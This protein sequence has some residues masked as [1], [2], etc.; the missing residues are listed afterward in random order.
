MYKLKRFGTIYN[1]NMTKEIEDTINSDEFQMRK[2][3]EKIEEL[4][5]TIKE[6]DIEIN[7]LKEQNNN[8]NSFNNSLPKITHAWKMLDSEED[9]IS[10]NNNN[11]NIEESDKYK[12]VL[13]ELN[14]FKN[15]YI[16]IKEDYIK[17]QK[18]NKPKPVDVENDE[19]YL[20]LKDKYDNLLYDKE[21]NEYEEKINI[22]QNTIKELN[23][24]NKHK[25]DV[26]NNENV[27][28]PNNRVIDILEKYPITV[29]K[30]IGES[31]VKKMVAAR[32]A[33]LVKYQY[34]IANKTNR[35]GEDITL[36]ETID[37]IIEQED[38]PQQRKTKLKY[39]FERCIFLHENYKDKINVLKFSISNLGY[40]SK[41]EWILWLNELNNIIKEIYPD[42]KINDITHNICNYT[43]KNGNICNKFNCKNKKHLDIH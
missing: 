40:I 6:K 29:Y 15:K 41:K 31:I 24:N 28:K 14:S 2:L 12:Q 34:E 23:K 42:E 3:Y 1:N 19:K 13:K 20:S 7:L 21:N 18:E 37:Y 36:D 17:I 9:N 43:Y 5:K 27:K 25:Q 4:E 33:Y 32:C 38:L 39:E 26:D 35:E 11:I 16:D 10:I 8:I 30:D 22:L